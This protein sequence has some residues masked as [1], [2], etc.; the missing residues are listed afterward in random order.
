MI[1]AIGIVAR[2]FENHAGVLALQGGGLDAVAGKLKFV[3]F[4]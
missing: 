1:S 4:H 3:L 2:L